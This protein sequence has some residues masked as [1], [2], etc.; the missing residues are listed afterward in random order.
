MP[1]MASVALLPLYF[2][3]FLL[4]CS[5]D[6]YLDITPKGQTLLDNLDDLELLATGN[7]SQSCWS[8]NNE[9]ILV[10]DAYGTARSF[11]TAVATPNTLTHALLTYDESVDRVALSESDQKYTRNYSSIAAL[12]E[13]IAQAPNVSGD[14]A[15]KAYLVAIA[16]VK[17][18]YFHYLIML[19]FCKQYDTATAATE[20]GIP[21][22][23]DIK[24]AEENQKLTLAET[25]EHLLADCSDDVLADLY[26]EPVN[27]ELPGKAFGYAVRAKILLQMK[28][29]SEALKYANLSLQYNSSIEDRTPAVVAGT[30]SRTPQAEQNLFYCEGMSSGAGSYY[31][32]HETAQ[33]FEDGDILRDYTD[34][35][36]KRIASG[37]TDSLW[38]WAAGSAYRYNTGGITT[39]QM[40]YVAA[41][42]NIRTGDIQKGMNLINQVRQYRVAPGKYAPLTASTE[43]E[44]M[45]VLQR[46]KR[47]ECLF[48]Y[49]TFADMKRWNTESA[50]AATV[51][52]NLEGNSYSLS[53]TSDLWVSPFPQDATTYNSSL[54]QNY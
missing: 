34:L 2:F 49:N 30:F 19:E 9:E 1:F 31:I 38:C 3:S 43:A 33:L 11:M 16:K 24:P 37:V 52:R 47:I 7:Y 46:C 53:P 26:D 42:C 4:F 40:Y 21:Y 35:W 27:I 44:A 20:G 6:D 29:Y 28:N 32:S 22:V 18:A 8:Y 12:N 23:T 39:E 15:R 5:C 48:T 14:N 10:N 45:A 41:E 25:Y 17:R 54:T 13:V 51:T 36:E 50:Y